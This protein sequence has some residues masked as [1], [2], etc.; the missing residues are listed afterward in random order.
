MSENDKNI[1]ETLKQIDKE[2]L[3]IKSLFYDSQNNTSYTDKDSINNQNAISINKIKQN[4]SNLNIQLKSE[5]KIQDG[6]FKEASQGKENRFWVFIAILV[7]ALITF[8]IIAIISYSNTSREIL[9]PIENL[10]ELILSLSKG[11]FKEINISKTNDE[12]GEMVDATQVMIKSM[13]AKTNFAIEIG[14]KNYESDFEILSNLD[15][16]GNSLLEMRRNLKLNAENDFQINWITSGIAQ[17]GEILRANNQEETELHRNIIKF[18]VRYLEINQG[19][20]LILNDDYEDDKYL[21]LKSSYAYDKIKKNINKRISISE[22]M[23]GECFFDKETIFLTEIPDQYV[24]ITSGLGHKT[25]SCILMVPLTYNNESFGAIEL[26]SFSILKP[27]E[28]KFVKRIAENIASTISNVKVQTRTQKLLKDLQVQ[29]NE[30]RGQEEELRQN[31]EELSATQESM[32]QNQKEIT[33][34]LEISKENELEYKKSTFASKQE[35]QI[36]TSK[37]EFLEQSLK[38][39]LNKNN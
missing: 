15:E 18:L 8:I 6:L 7:V 21:E 32:R 13:K 23:L 27:Y 11:E 14:K 33:K 39:N 19:G 1:L 35:I 2:M 31:L 29:K 9:R 5:L 34:L 24:E 12:L 25:P 17:I 28:I 16:L 26:A 36:L 38:N 20:L 3:D 22:G 30:M 4:F 10:K 37:I